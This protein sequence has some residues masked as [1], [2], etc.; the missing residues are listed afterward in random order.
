MI[1]ESEALS[2]SWYFLFMKV[3]INILY[4][5]HFHSAFCTDAFKTYLVLNHKTDWSRQCS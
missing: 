1:P 3:Y 2:A 4:M 5:E